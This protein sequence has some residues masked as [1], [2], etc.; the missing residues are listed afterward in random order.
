MFKKRPRRTKADEESK[1]TNSGAPSLGD[2]KKK[3]KRSNEEIVKIPRPV[4]RDSTFGRVPRAVVLRVLGPMLN[5]FDLLH[6]QLTCRTLETVAHERMREAQARTMPRMEWI[7]NQKRGTLSKHESVALHQHVATNTRVCRHSV[8]TGSWTKGYAYLDGFICRCN[9]QRFVPI[10]KRTVTGNSTIRRYGWSDPCLC[11]SARGKGMCNVPSDSVAVDPP[12]TG[13]LS[14]ADS[15]SLM[16]SLAGTGTRAKVGEWTHIPHGIRARQSKF[17][18]EGEANLSQGE[19]H[20]HG[21]T[22]CSL[23]KDG[24]STHQAVFQGPPAGIGICD[25]DMKSIIPIG[26]DRNYRICGTYCWYVDPKES[27]RDQFYQI[28]WIVRNK[29]LAQHGGLD[30]QLIRQWLAEKQ[31]LTLFQRTPV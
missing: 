21:T 8:P 28:L 16:A 1:G 26:A 19:T 25:I 22:I 30:N 3:G 20:Y 13:S 15:L 11:L 23:Y 24:S 14:D 17:T 31:L 6:L 4:V 10:I 27:E 7:C 18:W 5:I 9:V 12:I 29:L 2:T